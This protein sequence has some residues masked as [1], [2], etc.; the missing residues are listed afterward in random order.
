MLD[1]AFREPFVGFTPM[2]R[3]EKIDDDVHRR[4]LVTVERG[5]FIGEESCRVVRANNRGGLTKY[6]RRGQDG[7]QTNEGN[8]FHGYYS[9]PT[10]GA[11]SSPQER[12]K[13]ELMATVET[14]GTTKTPTEDPRYPA[15]VDRV[16]AAVRDLQDKGIIDCQGKR[17]RQDLPPDMQEDAGRDFGG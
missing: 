5:I 15:A 1:V 9:L 16:R 3:F 10:D 6:R 13:M 4:L 7:E 12:S 8:T 14:S 2:A 17:V 11:L